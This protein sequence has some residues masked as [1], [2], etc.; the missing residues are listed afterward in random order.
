MKMNDNIKI[1]ND[2]IA[3]IASIAACEVKGIKGLHGGNIVDGI[4]KTFSKSATTK[5]VAVDMTNDRIN[6][7]VS[8]VVEYGCKINPVAEK[9]QERVRA[10]IETMT[11]ISNITVNVFVAGL[12]IEDMEAAACE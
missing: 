9:V 3:K 11:G 1:S 5:G 6:V 8:V 2:V 4:V 7:S 12:F 10:D